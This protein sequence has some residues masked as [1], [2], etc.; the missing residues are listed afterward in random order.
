MNPTLPAEIFSN[1][2]A[3]SWRA[4]VMILVLAGLRR[5]V[6][7]RVPAQ[8]WFTV[9]AV[10]AV[11]LLLP[12]S[13][14]V[15]AKETVLHPVAAV[16]ATP[17][18][19]RNADGAA[20]IVAP[21][22][23]GSTGQ[24]FTSL[25]MAAKAGSERLDIER[26]SLAAWLIGVATLI[27]IWAGASWRFR[28]RL[29]TAS[30]VTDSRW[31][32]ILAGEAQAAG[33]KPNIVSL[34][35]PWVDA[36]ALSGGWRPRLLLPTGL[37]AK[38]TD[39]ELRFVIRHELAHWRRRDG[40]VLGLLRAA[41]V[42]H[43]FNPLVWLAARLARADCE[44]ACDECVLRR[45]ADEEEG[46]AY[47]AALLRVL[48]LVGERLRPLS[49]VGLLENRH[50]LADRVRRIA[51]YQAVGWGRQMGAAAGVAAV[52][53]LAAAS[54]TR[55]V[56][57]AVQATAEV[58]EKK[59]W[60]ET[61]LR[62]EMARRKAEFQTVD[63]LVD[64]QKTKVERIA[65]QLQAFKEKNQLKGPGGGLDSQQAALET[66]LR[67]LNLERERANATLKIEEFRAQQFKAYAEGRIGLESLPLRAGDL[68]VSRALRNVAAKQATL[69]A[70][71]PAD[72]DK[73]EV[74]QAKGALAGAEA[75][76]R[77]A[78]LSMGELVQTQYQTAQKQAERAEAEW[79]QIKQQSAEVDRQKLIYAN[80]E[81]EL[82]V[83]E[84]IL[85]K[86]S[87]RARTTSIDPR[88]DDR[89]V[90][91]TVAGA[92][93]NPGVVSFLPDRPPTIVQAIAQAGFFERG[94][95][96][97][98]VRLSRRD[99]QGAV[100]VREIDLAAGE[101]VRVEPD[102][103]ILVTQKPMTPA[104]IPAELIERM[105][106]LSASSK[107]EAQPA[108]L[109]AGAAVSAPSGPAADQAVK[110]QV[111]VMGAVGRPGVV[112]FSADN[113]LTILDAISRVGAFSRMA[114]T[115]H[116]RLMRRNAQGVTSVSV[117]DIDA[118]T[119][120]GTPPPRVEPGDGILVPERANQ[121]AINQ[122]VPIDAA[123]GPVATAAAKTEEKP[124]SPEAGASTSASTAPRP[125]LSGRAV[126]ITGAV[127]APGRYALPQNEK[128][129]LLDLIVTAG[130]FTRVADGKRVKLTRLLADGGMETY[131]IDVISLLQG[132]SSSGDAA[133]FI[134]EPG[135]IIFVKE[136]IL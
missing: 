54:F 62:E 15:T 63:A 78:A 80:M 67:L 123:V 109:E 19:T 16:V 61:E 112:S 50:Q 60:S 73:S 17:A 56:R 14:G 26:A 42:V 119:R 52:A 96:R 84:A 34:E 59:V 65:D 132:E 58:T 24:A 1:L 128:L 101:P 129:S 91:L 103:F 113:P 7:G 2:L 83:Q 43:W 79:A 130:G 108:T 55:E 107:T 49:A 99:A 115:K 31:L 53:L 5:W 92:V 110:P 133:K 120:D 23:V 45:G 8:I 12:L 104:T 37:I 28:R 94:A 69:K 68:E 32:A 124:V 29:K 18:A 117:F 36:P 72:H 97:Q 30:P 9:W 127:G 93:G 134:L 105:A 10:V 47:G 81:R 77:N 74:T 126:S 38:L 41:V 102:D 6:R 82:T 131:T 89:L 48:E 71:N 135:D 64:S 75:A 57:A 136:K 40:W 33:L 106:A 39:G 70:L 66:R 125:M 87:Q 46:S 121:A 88:A 118:M 51:G 4:G 25:Q 76:L 95:D 116:V 13:V 98:H 86:T 3:V 20:A 35:T 90:K 27:V 22:G 44:A 122:R 11:R 21:G 85:I 111:T 114:D 100:V